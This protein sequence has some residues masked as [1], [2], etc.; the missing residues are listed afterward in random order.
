MGTEFELSHSPFIRV[1]SKFG[2][3]EIDLFASRINA[4][5]K[6]YVFWMRDSQSMPS[7]LLG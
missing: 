3:S 4:K 6:N 2:N 1:V 5:Y 7:L